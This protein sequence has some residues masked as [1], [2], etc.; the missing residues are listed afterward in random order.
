MEAV[1]NSAAKADY[2]ARQAMRADGSGIDADGWCGRRIMQGKHTV[3]VLVAE[4]FAAPKARAV[5]RAVRLN[6][7][8]LSTALAQ[9]LRQPA[10]REWSGAGAGGDAVVQSGRD[11]RLSLRSSCLVL[12]DIL[13][14]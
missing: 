13:H 3:A 8:I 12:A 10:K 4:F 9:H 6:I 11:G 14:F 5:R 7:V 1:S 2:H